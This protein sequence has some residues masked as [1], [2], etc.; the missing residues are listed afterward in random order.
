MPR[1][2]LPEPSDQLGDDRLV[3]AVPE[4]RALATVLTDLLTTALDDR[5][6]E[7]ND[8]PVE[9]GGSDPLDGYGR[10]SSSS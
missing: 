5:G 10:L 6:L 9:Q 1:W 4:R 7:R 3:L 2:L 8:D